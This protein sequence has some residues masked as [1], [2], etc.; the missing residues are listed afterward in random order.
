MKKL[1]ILGM[2]L[3]LLP[4]SLAYPLIISEV[5]EQHSENKDLIYSINEDN[6]KD[7][8]KVVFTE[9][10]PRCVTYDTTTF[11]DEEYPY[12]TYNGYGNI[13]FRGWFWSYT[14]S[15]DCYGNIYIYSHSSKEE[16]RGILQHELNHINAFCGG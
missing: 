13:C 11:L 10:F 9:D 12:L 1:M 6:Y 5:N 2:M 15:Y 3:F 14:T 16:K 4:I 8:N 7:V